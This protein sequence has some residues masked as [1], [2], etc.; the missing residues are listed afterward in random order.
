MTEIML[1]DVTLGQA[2]INSTHKPQNS[3]D[4][5]SVKLSPCMC[6]H[7]SCPGWR[8]SCNLVRPTYRTQATQSCFPVSGP[9]SR[10]KMTRPPGFFFFQKPKLKENGVQQQN[11]LWRVKSGTLL[12]HADNCVSKN[13]KY[14]GSD[15]QLK[16]KPQKHIR[17]SSQKK[18]LA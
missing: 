8:N 18:S 13:P 5:F 3:T 14:V 16:L 9:T 2:C 6:S 11:A 12:Q 1:V 10:L 7:S 17:C 15:F 4:D